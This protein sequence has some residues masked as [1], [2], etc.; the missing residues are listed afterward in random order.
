[1][2]KGLPS[3]RI[4]VA[5]MS[6]GEIKRKLAGPR[7]WIYSKD[8]SISNR[9]AIAGRMDSER[10]PGLSAITERL[11]AHPAKRSSLW[12]MTTNRLIM[13][14]GG[15]NRSPVAVWPP[16][17]LL[18]GGVRLW[19]T[20]VRRGRKRRRGWEAMIAAPPAGASPTMPRARAV[21]WKPS[22]QAAQ[23][24]RKQGPLE[25]HPARTRWVPGAK[26]AWNGDPPN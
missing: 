7:L 12:A 16:T 19:V 10:L 3:L 15:G 6:S 14:R 8:S 17:I 18:H 2:D 21:H 26:L 4:L 23:V 5:V 11:S 24:L 20:G 9:W 1:M 13:R 25:Q 22:M